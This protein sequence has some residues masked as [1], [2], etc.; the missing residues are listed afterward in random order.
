MNE[1]KYGKN[2]EAAESRI[3]FLWQFCMSVSLLYLMMFVAIHWNPEVKSHPRPDR[4]PRG[5]AYPA[6]RCHLWRS[7]SSSALA[8]E[9]QFVV[10]EGECKTTS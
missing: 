8:D 4:R 2:M 5:L 6:S 1:D 10:R 3:L 7:F 9:S